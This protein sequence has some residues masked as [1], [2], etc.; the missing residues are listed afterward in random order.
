[1]ES[2]DGGRP[3]IALGVVG[4][5]EACVIAGYDKGGEVLYGRS[6]F[7]ES[8][9]G[10]FSTDEWFENCHGLIL[11]GDK[12]GA[13]PR[14]E[15]LRSTLEWAIQ[16]ARVPEFERYMLGGAQPPGRVI[17]GLAAYD[18]MTEALLRDEDFDFPADDMDTMEMRCFAISN[19]GLHLLH[20]KRRAAVSFLNAIADNGGPESEDLRTAARVYSEE[21]DVL[22]PSLRLAPN[23]FKPQKERLKLCDRGRRDNLAAIVREAKA[24]DERAVGHLEEALAKL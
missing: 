3:V 1:M 16:L 23:S 14:R 13:P 24:H 2:I 8:G 20:W 6:Y 22:E 18:A 11:L 15:V 21:V 9:K 12:V 10:Y 4:P 19:D 17:S 7:Q 5:P